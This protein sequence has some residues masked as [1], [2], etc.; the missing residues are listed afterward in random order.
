RVR[1]ALEPRL[2][3]TVRMVTQHLEQE[4]DDSHRDRQE[5]VERVGGEC[6]GP[7][8]ERWQLVELR[9]SLLQARLRLGNR[10]GG[11]DLG[12]GQSFPLFGFFYRGSDTRPIGSWSDADERPPLDSL[13]L[14]VADC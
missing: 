8:I 9:D 5:V 13:T 7:P 14:R 11:R 4:V 10:C 6:A 2:H 1:K 12:I 3:L